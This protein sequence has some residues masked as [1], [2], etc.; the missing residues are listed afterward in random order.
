MNNE[1]AQLLVRKR[2][3]MV[4]GLTIAMMLVLAGAVQAQAT[5]LQ[6]L[7][8]GMTAA[9]GTGG[10]YTGTPGDQTLGIPFIITVNAVDDS[11][12]KVSI[13]DQISISSSDPYA[14]LPLPLNLVN[15]SAMLTITLNSSG[16]QAISAHDNSNPSVNG[17]TSPPVSVLNLS[18]FTISDIGSP[19][20][21]YPGEVTVGNSIKNVEVTA[22]DSQGNRLYNYSGSV[23]LSE[24]TDYGVGRIYPE[25]V[26]LVDG[27][28][29]GTIK[30]YRAGKKTKGWGVTGDAWVS[31]E[32]NGIDGESN[33]F[34]A[35]PREFSKLLTIVPGE[36]SL[37]GSTTGKSGVALNQQANTE[38]Y[39]DVYAT[40]D[41]F[42]PRTNIYH[43]I[44]LT[45]SDN[46][47]VLPPT[48]A[49][50]DG[51]VTL[52]VKLKSFGQKTVT[53]IDM[54]DH[55]I[56]SST[57]SDITVIAQGVDHFVIAPISSPRTAGSA[58]S[59][60]ISAKDAAGNPVN[61]YNGAIDI[62]VRTGEGTFSPTDIYMSNGQWTG[63]ITI[64]KA[65][66]S[67]AIEVED[68]LQPPHAGTSNSF[69][70]QPGASTKLQVLMP[71]ESATP[72][73]APG[74]SGAV[75]EILAGT[76]IT[77]RVNSVDAWWNVVSSTP[78]VI[79]LESSDP[80]AE[81][82]ND[83]SLING[84][85]QFQVTLNTN[86][87]QTVT[88]EDVT[89]PSV[90][91]GISSAIRV[92]PGNVDHFVINAINGPKTAGTP[93]GMIVTAVDQLGN[94][95][96]DFSGS[97]SLSASTGNGTFSPATANLINGA[98]SGNGYV[99]KAADGVS[100][101]VTDSGSPEHTGN[102]NEF[103]VLAGPITKL[104]VLAPG[105]TATPGKIPGY[106][107]S[108]EAQNLGKLFSV[109]VN[110]VDSYW[111]PVSSANDSFGVSA[112][113]IHAS[114]PAS[115]RLI[116]GSRS[117]TVA[118]NTEGEF[119]VSAFHLTNPAIQNGQTPL[120]TI[121]PQNLDHFVVS[122]ISGS[123]AAGSPVRVTLQAQTGTSERVYG[124][125]G[126]VNISASTGAGT[127]LPERVGPFIE[128]EWTGDLIFTKAATNVSI[129]VN[130]GGSP[131]HSGISNQFQV[132]AGALVKLQV[133][134][135]GETGTPGIAPGKTGSSSSIMSGTEIVVRVNAID[136]HW[137]VVQS[138]MDV[139]HLESSDELAGL[140][141]DA[142]LVNGTRQMLVTMNSI[143]SH[144]ITAYNQTA[145][146][147]T[148]GI[149]STLNVNPGN[150][151]KFNILPINGPVVAGQ[152]HS[153]TI[154]AVD[155]R[156]NPV[157][158]YAGAV[159]LA[160]STGEGSI[161]PVTANLLNGVWTGDVIFKKAAEGVYLT[162]TDGASP[163]HS[164]SSN[165]FTVVAGQLARMQIL[166]PG[167][168][169]TPG[170][171][172]G[173]VG[174]PASQNVGQPFF[175][176]LNAV[177]SYW[178]IVTL[179][180]DSV[181]LSATD[182]NA[183]LPEGIQ[184]IAG[185]YT[186]SVTINSD[187]DHALTV[188]HK[189][190]PQV[191]TGQSPLITVLP[192][193]L[194]HFAITGISGTV[195]AGEPIEITIRARD[196][197]DNNV[198]NFTGTVSLAASS[199]EGTVTPNQVGPLVKGEWTG[200]IVLTKAGN[201]VVL[202]VRDGASPPHEGESAQFNVVAGTFERLQVLLP[203]EITAPGTES[204]KSGAVLDQLTGSQFDVMVN[205]VD[206][207]WN[208]VAGITDSV[209][210][211]CT[212]TL[213]LLPKAAS[214]LN[215]KATFTVIMG[216]AGTHSM[217][218]E[219][220]SNASI[221]KGVSSTLN[222]NPGN[223]DRF[224]FQA[225]QSQIAG[226]SFNVT[227]AAMDVAG[228]PVTGFNGRARIQSSTGEGTIS[229]TEIE[230]T[231]GQW[232]GNVTVSRAG[233]Q[234]KLTCRDFAATP[235]SGQSAAFQVTPGEFTQLQVLVPGETGTPGIAPGKSG[236]AS[237][238]IVGDAL[239]VI[240]NA[241]DSWWNPIPA[242]TGTIGLTSTDTQANLPLDAA[243][244]TGTVTFSDMRFSSPG[245]WTITAHY[246]SGE[247]I[248]SS[249][250]SLIRVITGSVASFVFD[251]INSP[252]TAGDSIRIVVRA[253]DGSGSIVDSYN[254]AASMTV[255]T[256]P[257]T[258][259]GSDIEFV[260]G[261]WQGSVRLTKSAQSVHLNIHD[262]ADVVRGNS[263][264]FTLVPGPLA[265]LQVILDG[266]TAQPG[267]GT[268]R[269][270]TPAA[271]VIGVP[272]QVRVNTTDVWWNTVIPD[273][274]P[275]YFA[276][277]DK[278]ADVPA[279]TIQTKSTT[280]YSMTL[281][282]EG[283]HRII[284]S[285]SKLS[286][287]PDTSTTFYAQSGQIHHFV[288]STIDS[289][290]VAGRP[291]TIRIDAFNQYNYP[292]VDFEG[293]IIISAS[294]GNGTITQTGVTLANGTWTGEIAVT[295]S[296]S[297]VIL[298]AADYVPAPNTH[299]G[300]SNTFK[301]VPDTLAGLQVLL[302]GETATPGVGNA[303][304]G[305]PQSSIAGNAVTVNVRAVDA[306]WNIRTDVDSTI[307]LTTSDSFA[308]HEFQYT[309]TQGQAAIP[310]N[311]RAARSHRI[312][313][314]FMDAD[315][316]SN[317]WSDTVNIAA[318]TFSQLVLLMPGETL[319]PGDTEESS[320][321]TPGR[322][323]KAIAQ[324]SGLA[325]DVNVVAVDDYWNLVTNAPAD[326]VSMFATD[327]NAII[328]PPDTLLIAGQA[329]FSV[330]L[331]QG[332]NQVLRA[333]NQTNTA[334]QTVNE[335]VVE[336]I[337]GGLHYE[338]ELPAEDIIAGEE[339]N[340]TV[341][342]RNGIGETVASANQLVYVNAVK[343]DNMNEEAGELSLPS[344]NLQ[345]GKRT[346]KEVMNQVGSIR[347]EVFDDLGNDIA[348]SDP[349]DVIAGR[350]KTIEIPEKAK[351]LRALEKCTLT[352]VLKD[353]TD[354]PVAGEEVALQLVEGFGTLAQTSVV[355]DSSGTIRFEFT[356]GRTTESNIVRLSIDSLFVDMEIVINLTP[357][358]QPNGVPLNYPN[359]FGVES[360]VT[361][362][363]Y[364]LAED[365]DVS[366]RIYDLFG[367]LVWSRHIN[368]G[369]EGARGRANSSH[370]NSITWNGTNDRGKMVGNGG[371]ILVARAEANGRK[372]MDAKRKIA[373]L[374]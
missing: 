293:D 264:P 228:S 249:T 184:L 313:A 365:A 101:H 330:T 333:T 4:I 338:I 374:R 133:L 21:A 227:I 173:F 242:A 336:V 44:S 70:V 178:N 272:F 281:L 352:S 292:V 10:G 343:S 315:S 122:N 36:T 320:L 240:V 127:I 359:P 175:V 200:N 300:F 1:R 171:A 316:L 163:V 168:I 357:S 112:T 199:A 322:A 189:S 287:Q 65:S 51:R 24:T 115:S 348:Y 71:G 99:T 120:I 47:A 69:Q 104:Q 158:A 32:A 373:V 331:S 192:L 109:T 286:I 220:V 332:G 177:D 100:I 221:H 54:S 341:Y 323:G 304:K 182:A 195:T 236:E 218:A 226:K 160:A 75:Q 288:F 314:R 23:N 279:D 258:M 205:G 61:D 91:S 308:V 243:L 11:W 238:Q 34:C 59:I 193:N 210:I 259:I 169:A 78:D 317:A 194:D 154:Q 95:V 134:L 132:V 148:P 153:I 201:G 214:M 183:S 13:S 43:T 98:W 213:A 257:G 225:V 368:A 29:K 33:R 66:Q 46:Q 233:E 150:I 224:E 167:L 131:S 230:F 50:S 144:T 106:I 181:D 246:K 351:E 86:G 339:F 276:S 311:F 282:T 245:Y 354:N 62:S 301:I 141:S 261:M 283:H 202:N 229:P 76:P 204:G 81:L 198:S 270:G 284:V 191:Q 255:S 60:T 142:S 295:K 206:A 105:Q 89:N 156:N 234:V 52:A 274:L 262:F 57:S 280:T 353:G 55:S 267:I 174:S 58:F 318:A 136:A 290:F 196:D 72:G 327:Q 124:F 35:Q 172:P 305:E 5:K 96:S 135:P 117:V 14:S 126:H 356:A 326:R 252:Q 347:F 302:P 31:A 219:D 139:V 372:I 146:E 363:D 48:K 27:R 188:T 349:I 239:V 82:P 83:A 103:T 197:N 370:P 17:V 111:N 307:V 39:I 40:D 15:G 19:Y 277:T 371:Y 269:Q 162:V 180:S 309:L 186:V 364:Y 56:A 138:S 166:V 8:P 87:L 358:S 367:N 361:T 254:E 28:W 285:S 64:T 165:E 265:R 49:M 251:P 7:L 63:N 369:A 366:L 260:N 94:P 30:I 312:G 26:Q 176:V 147:I 123:I 113:D 3:A 355:S 271:Q 334:I 263:N 6:I 85:R 116:N 325:F 161:M 291:F 340:L 319:L 231:N 164:G 256:G 278:L 296:D 342:F 143:G 248:S 306:W 337:V 38:F 350:V 9:P 190:N 152:A 294:T 266:E 324:T 209:K 90:S 80:E 157:Q 253:V 149:S 128:G 16:S 119:T 207:H 250:S 151:A 93:F 118:M 121:L 114:L 79:H 237:P 102:S 273:S 344:F 53:A 275:I 211:V 129:Q 97:I 203:G 298:Y 84:T 299:T 159:T 289:E 45:S 107:G 297:A 68:R 244:Q 185:T 208:L 335:T 130:D 310:I 241:V 268:G 18:Y 145:P 232:K 41:Y 362:I 179:S 217:T 67:T 2:I 170:I 88:A 212:D 110:G 74:K 42:N 12:N 137:N 321:N 77:I 187:G 329:Q 346:V 215:G 222:V 223:L 25:T 92:N 360:D 22:R 303:R 125:D 37:P 247:Q 155:T 345:T 73:L 328:Y 20:W 140:P 108:P 235:H 216:S